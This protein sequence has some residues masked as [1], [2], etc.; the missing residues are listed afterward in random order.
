MVSLHLI[1][2]IVSSPFYLGAVVEA[3]PIPLSDHCG[4]LMA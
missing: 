2:R 1:L 4:E 3:N